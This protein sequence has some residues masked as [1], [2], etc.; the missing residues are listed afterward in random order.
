MNKTI[1]VNKLALI[2]IIKYP[3]LTDKTTQMIEENKYYFAVEVKAKKTK[4]KKAIE[5]LFDVKVKR[6]NTLI[7]KP[8][9]KRIGKYMGYKSKYKKAIITLYDPYKINLFADN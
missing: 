2:D 5:Q 1:Q 9:K 3:I 8:Q 4:I 7:V 6:V